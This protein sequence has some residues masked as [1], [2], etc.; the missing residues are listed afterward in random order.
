M[1]WKMEG[2]KPNFVSALCQCLCQAKT[3]V[4]LNPS[5]LFKQIPVSSKDIQH[6]GFA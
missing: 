6:L 3:I 5:L 2:C 1:F 4:R